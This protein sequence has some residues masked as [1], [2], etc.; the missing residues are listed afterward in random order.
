MRLF[1]LAA[2]AF[3][4]TSITASGLRNGYERVWLWYAY[5]IDLELPKDQRKIG[6]R[7]IQFDRPN[8]RCPD[9]YPEKNRKGMH[10]HKMPNSKVLLIFIPSNRFFDW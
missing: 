4:A 8:N 6:V 5:Q 7:C 9:K 2:F 1:I 3:L 10:L